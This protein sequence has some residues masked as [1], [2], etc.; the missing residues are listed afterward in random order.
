MIVVKRF[1]KE[2]IRKYYFNKMPQELAT[3]LKRLDPDFI[4]KSAI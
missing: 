3:D 4:K 2:L 1:G